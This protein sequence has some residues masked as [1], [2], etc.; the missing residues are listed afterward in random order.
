[1][2]PEPVDSSVTNARNELLIEGAK[3][4]VNAFNALSEFRREVQR[5]CR[6]V[7]EKRISELNAATGFHLSMDR[8]DLSGKP[9]QFEEAGWNGSWATMG[10]KIDIPGIA[11]FDL[12]LF[13]DLSA[14]KDCLGIVVA[15]RFSKREAMKAFF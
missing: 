6:M 12:Y 2:P 11:F 10:T 9:Q 7:L 13:W 1:M 5:I 4:F 14:S 8:A 15:L 3:S